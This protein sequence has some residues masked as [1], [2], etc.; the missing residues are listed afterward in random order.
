M[1]GKK[2]YEK[3]VAGKKTERYLLILEDENLL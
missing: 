1:R 2:E 3:K